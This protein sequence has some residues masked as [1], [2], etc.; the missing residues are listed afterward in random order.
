MKLEL[1]RSEFLKAWQ[2]AERSCNT[3]STVSA[4]SGILITALDEKVILE[5]TDFKTAVRCAAGGVKVLASGSAV[6]PVRLLGEF[7]KKIS[8]DTVTL[9]INSERGVLTAGRNRMR[10]S[11][12]PTSEFPDIPRSEG[13][14]KL[15][16]VL[17]ADLVKVIGE[18]S[19]ASSTPADFPKYLGACFI[20]IKDGLLSVVSTDSKRLSLSKCPCECEAEEE[21]LLPVP[22]LKELSRLAA[23][24]SQEFRVQLLNDGSTVWF[25]LEGV[26]FSIR[27]VE[28]SF[29]N[30]EKILTSDVSTTL[31]I[32]R[33]EILPAL[34]RVDI[35]AKNTASHVAALQIS[36]GGDLK[37]SVKASDFGTVLEVLSAS[38][39]GDPL[40]VGFNVS[41]LQ[42][43]LKALSSGEAIIQFNGGVGQT[44]ILQEGM[45]NF[46][47]MLM[48]AMI[49]PQDLLEGDE[50]QDDEEQDSGDQAD[51]E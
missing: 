51:P 1:N 15:C 31:R 24:G 11:T 47:Y 45:D 49:N 18:G 21:L 41:Y 35:I 48:P 42:D 36:P 46:L 5:A 13:A 9:E 16:S 20:K 2:V 23:S 28:S 43:G 4:I 50:E 19:I 7:L 22:A 38:V 33:D 29:P 27:R 37:I 26:E 12:F 14:S 30:Y 3:K 32:R 17:T 34:E 10:F 39:E 44:R 8:A 25:D 40:Q 6:L